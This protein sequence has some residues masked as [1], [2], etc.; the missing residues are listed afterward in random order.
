MATTLKQSG[1]S[2][3]IPPEPLIDV[4]A[5]IHVWERERK[6]PEFTKNFVTGLHIEPL[7]HDAVVDIIKRHW[8]CFYGASVKLPILH[9]EFG[10]DAGASPP[11][12][13]QKPHCRPHESK[14]IIEHLEALKANGWTRKCFGAWGSSII[15]AAKPHQQHVMS[16]EEFIWR[17]CVSC[18]RLNQVTLPFEHPIPCCDNAVDNFGNSACRLFLIALDNKTGH[19]QILVCERDR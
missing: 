8:D 3:C 6:L 18:R 17:S 1:E 19:H 14:I 9:F 15:F 13:R 10:V 5:N 4:P 2:F 7:I 16:I 12:C 11:I